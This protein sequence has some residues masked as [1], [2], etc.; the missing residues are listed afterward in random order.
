MANHFYLSPSGAH[1]WMKCLAAPSMESTCEDKSSKYADEGT[2]AHTVAQRALTHKKPA[3]FFIGEEIVVSDKYF[4]FASGNMPPRI[5]V[6]DEMAEHVQTYIDNLHHY[7]MGNEIEVEVKVNLG[8]YIQTPM[9]EGGVSEIPFGTS[10]AVILDFAKKE[11]QVHDYKHGKGVR[12]DAENN[13]QLMLY[14]LGVYDLYGLLGDFEHILLVIHQ[15]RIGHLSEWQ[16]TVNELLAFG[17]TAREKSLQAATLYQKFKTQPILPDYFTPGEDQCYFCKAK[18]KCAAFAQYTLNNVTGEFIDLEAPDLRDQLANAV[19]AAD[20]PN[21]ISNEKLGGL[22][23]YVDMLEDLTRVYRARIER[24]LFAGHT[25]PGW[26][27]VQG[28]RGARYWVSEETV[29]DIL[30]NSMRLSDEEIYKFTLIS[31]AQAEKKFKDAP[32][33]WERLLE[34]INQED[35]KPSVAPETDKRPALAVHLVDSEVQDW[36]L[37]GLTEFALGEVNKIG[38]F[39]FNR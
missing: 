30:K 19:T 26:K 27:L 7:A 6:T 15:P 34:L 33:R 22:M 29:V 38:D 5:T 1:R 25:V 10:D 35:G 23:K 17:K 39:P 24:E 31:P 20:D 3:A 21:L 14:A 28:K 32:K 18:D 16:I 37:Q 2:A 13:E 12:V 11:I 8:A 4:N 9:L 36:T